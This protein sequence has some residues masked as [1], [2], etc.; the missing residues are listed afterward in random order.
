MK[1]AVLINRGNIEPGVELLR[2]AL[3]K[4]RA[5][6][7]ELYTGGLCL[8]L[9]DGLGASGRLDEALTALDDT[10][11]IVNANGGSLDLPE[12][13]RTKGTLLARAGDPVGAEENLRSSLAL[14]RSHSAL[15]LQLR[16]AMSFVRLKTCQGDPAEACATLADIYG[17]FTEGFDTADLRAAKGILGEMNPV[18]IS[19]PKISSA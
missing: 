12:L 6:H 11:A 3:A 10:I 14:A 7:Y 4:L 8:A 15:S 9:A 5:D 16:T 13:L 1:G 2:A 19:T 17:R 18:S